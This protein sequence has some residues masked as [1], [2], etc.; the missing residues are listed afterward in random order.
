MKK[1]LLVLFIITLTL[2]L[3]ITSFCS[4]AA[5]INETSAE[6]ISPEGNEGVLPEPD[7]E[8]AEENVF[9]TLY[10]WVVLNAGE[11]F[12]LL[13]LITSGLLAFTYK[14]GLLPKLGGALGKISSAVGSISKSTDDALSSL[15]ENYDRIKDNL[16]TVSSLCEGLSD[17]I[18]TLSA[19]LDES[20]DTKGELEKMKIILSSQVDM[21]YEIFLS[22]ALPQFAKEAVAERVSVM[23]RA[24]EGEASD[25][26]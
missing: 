7:G 12:S 18:S 3:S 17:E 23:R 4:G 24:L 26:E 8:L 22:S 20:A 10:N 15:G 1:F 6:N 5:S 9:T 2:T 25:N 13:T 19:R 16:S 11:I 21:L 14:K